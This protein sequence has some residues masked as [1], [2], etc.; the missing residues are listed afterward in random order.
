MKRL[1]T[2]MRAFAKRIHRY[3]FVTASF[4]GNIHSCVIRYS[5]K[6]FDLTSQTCNDVQVQKISSPSQVQVKSKSAW[7][8][9]KSSQVQVRSLK[10]LTKS[11][12]VHFLKKLIKSSPFSIKIGLKSKSSP[13][14]DLDL[15]I[16]SPFSIY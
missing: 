3:F 1:E 8:C 7:L 5:D 13:S 2:L 9:I 4:K 11:S 10:K 15:H 14:L 16:I 6:C 12:Q